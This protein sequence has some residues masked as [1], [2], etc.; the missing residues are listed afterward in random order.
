MAKVCNIAS[1]ES[2]SWSGTTGLYD[3]VRIFE[4]G[5][6]GY[7]DI[8]GRLVSVH[9]SCDI[10]NKL[11][12]QN[13]IYQYVYEPG[14]T[15][16]M[17]NDIPFKRLLVRVGDIHHLANPLTRTYDFLR[18]T[19]ARYINFQTT[20][21]WC[22]LYSSLGYLTRFWQD[23]SESGRF[24]HRT[25]AYDHEKK[26]LS[27]L[28]VAFCGSLLAQSHP[29]RSWYVN[30]L[31][32]HGCDLQIFPVAS[33]TSWFNNLSNIHFLVAPSLN[34]QISH[35]LYTPLF[36]GC[37]VL[38]D[39]ISRPLGFP[40][41][42]LP[43]YEFGSP[44][45]MADF[46]KQGEATLKS[47][48]KSTYSETKPQFVSGLLESEDFQGNHTPGVY[49]ERL[50]D[51]ES[52]NLPTHELTRGVEAISWSPEVF[53]NLLE[54]LQEVHRITKY[55]VFVRTSSRRLASLLCRYCPLSRIHV[56]VDEDIEC[57]NKDECIGFVISTAN[58]QQLGDIR[59]EVQ[60]PLA[61]QPWSVDG[62]RHCPVLD[63]SV[64]AEFKQIW[65]YRQKIH[66]SI[67][68]R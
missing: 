16:P 46:I 4:N 55:A 44:E 61:L 65:H 63:L 52:Y 15:Y 5:L 60:S 11:E 57:S 6:L 43:I 54:I 8:T 59:F 14:R 58:R 51:R 67:I 12:S 37:T 18:R 64:L 35:N 34:S 10:V 29:R 26:S 1:N 40:D 17:P 39:A 42:S 45:L 3:E 25:L 62:V 53:L 33:H 68:M 49:S 7:F 20:P 47:L 31:L 50:V 30:R 41:E 9:Q 2:G 38:T 32:Y 21:H 27:K 13:Y 23:L 48:W 56:I 36:L 19:G 24:A 66:P 22:E 28:C